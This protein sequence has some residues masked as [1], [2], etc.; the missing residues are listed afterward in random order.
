MDIFAKLQDIN[1]AIE[2]CLLE[3][4]GATPTNEAEKAKHGTIHRLKQID[5]ENKVMV[6]QH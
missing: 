1:S 4:S 3:L 6:R 2:V 5:K